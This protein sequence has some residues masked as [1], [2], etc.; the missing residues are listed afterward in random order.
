MTACGLMSDL[1]TDLEIEMN[2]VERLDHYANHLAVEAPV[3]F[4][5][6][7]PEPGWPSEGASNLTMCS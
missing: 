7:R 2:A 4:L 5:E 6:C 1:V 3:T